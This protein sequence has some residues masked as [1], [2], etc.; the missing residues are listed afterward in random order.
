MMRPPHLCPC[1]AWVSGAP[2]PL[3]SGRKST[4]YAMAS[5]RDRPPL[6]GMAADPCFQPKTGKLVPY[7][8]QARPQPLSRG[9]FSLKG[10]GSRHALE[11]S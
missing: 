3:G 9:H 2:L 7:H 8:E 1:V 4:A 6:S 5:G 10:D 11:S